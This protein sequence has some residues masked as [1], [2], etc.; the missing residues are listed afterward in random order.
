MPMW[1]RRVQAWA[2]KPATTDENASM[3]EK[4]ER[5]R[6]RLA[7]GG[8]L[9]ESLIGMTCVDAMAR[10]TEM[11]FDPQAV[12]PTAEAVTADFRANRVRLFLDESDRVIR[13]EAG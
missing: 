7:E 11:G 8:R 5:K 12:P 2:P 3:D 6:R 4:M 13:A 9:A 1:G 10:A